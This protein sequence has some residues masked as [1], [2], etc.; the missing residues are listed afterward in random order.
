M[1]AASGALIAF[2]FL[3]VSGF[4]IIY[5]TLDREFDAAHDLHSMPAD[6][7]ERR[8]LAV[9]GALHFLAFGALVWIAASLG[10]H[11]IAWAICAGCGLLLFLEHRFARN[12]DLAFFKINAWLSFA[13]LALVLAGRFLP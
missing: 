10:G 12:V 11:R 8:A 13:V 7:G 6:L 2:T 3:W 5:A 1:A 9:S 4:D